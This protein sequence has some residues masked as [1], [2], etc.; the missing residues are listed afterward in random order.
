[1]LTVLWSSAGA[2][3][4]EATAYKPRIF[5]GTPPTESANWTANTSGHTTTT[6]TVPAPGEPDLPATGVFQVRVKAANTA[7]SSAFSDPAD[8][9][10]GAPGPVTGLKCTAATDDG[11]TVSWDGAVGAESFEVE[12]TGIIAVGLSDVFWEAGG[13]PSGSGYA[14]AFDSLGRDHLFL[15]GVRAVNGEGDGPE[16]TVNC[17]T[18]D[19]DW[20]EVECTAT[21]IVD[22]D[23]EDPSGVLPEPSTP[24]WCRQ[25]AR[26][27]I[28]STTR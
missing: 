12:S 13:Q 7:G 5:T 27:G 24:A 6:A 28:A 25:R 3:L 22:A 11:F 17:R 18:V 8:A 10:C 20:L 1:M 2:G 14:H 4:A 16:S 19:D 9:T 26:S 21:G 15:A 23:W